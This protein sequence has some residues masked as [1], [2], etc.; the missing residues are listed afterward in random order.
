MYAQFPRKR[1]GGGDDPHTLDTHHCGTSGTLRRAFSTRNPFEKFL[2]IFENQMKDDEEY[3]EE[4]DEMTR[5]I[6]ESLKKTD[7]EYP[8]RRPVPAPT[9][10][11]CISCKQKCT[12]AC[13]LCGSP[14]HAVSHDPSVVPSAGAASA[15]KYCSQPLADVFASLCNEKSGAEIEACER[16]VAAYAS[17]RTES[18]FQGLGDIPAS[19][20]RTVCNTCVR[21]IENKVKSGLARAMTQGAPPNQAIDILDSGDEDDDA[22]DMP[23][24]KGGA[25]SNSSKPQKLGKSAW[26]EMSLLVLLQCGRMMNLHLSMQHKGPK[27]ERTQDEK[28]KGLK[29][30]IENHRTM[31]DVKLFREASSSSL[32]AKF[33]T[34]VK[35]AAAKV[36]KQERN[37]SGQSGDIRFLT[38]WAREAHEIAKEQFEKN[39]E[40]AEATEK[41]EEENRQM[42]VYEDD[43]GAGGRSAEEPRKVLKS[44]GGGEMQFCPRAANPGSVPRTYTKRSSA[45]PSTGTSSGSD[46]KEPKKGRFD[47]NDT[48]EKMMS[49]ADKD[50]RS[51]E[52][53]DAER[54]QNESFN[55]VLQSLPDLQK[56]V[57]GIA[58]V[59]PG[60]QNNMAAM[61]QQNA[62]TTNI[63]AA[64]LSRVMPPPQQ[65]PFNTPMAGENKQ[66]EK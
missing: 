17:H 64:L 6:I 52:E 7:P 1:E 39:M 44:T 5:A 57:T 61:T 47:F 62:Q 22:D 55:K 14:V 63:L 31:K 32:L 33:K 13:N 20:T 66:E 58:D 45:T 24:K 60:I 3:V 19:K 28:S 25:S 53:K 35:D 15:A 2:F 40:R 12:T 4:T 11:K 36:D 9:H 48:I 38:D 21:E 23:G 10:W 56:A 43:F 18:F 42:E 54:Q 50:D 46:A 34:L 16:L 51:Q 27:G 30:M 59:L 41:R 49:V 65:G 8:P 29:V 37:D 26:D